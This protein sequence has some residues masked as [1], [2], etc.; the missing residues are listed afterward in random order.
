LAI[1]KHLVELMGGRIRLESVPGRGSKFHIDL[2][3]PKARAAQAA[4]F[5]IRALA[6]SRMLVVDDNH[7]NLEILQRQLEAWQVTVTCA[8]SGEQA[9]RVMADAAAA[10]TG[11]N[12]AILDMHMPQ[13]DG[14]QLARRIKVQ[15]ALAATRLI[16]L[17]ST[18]AAGSS[19]ERVQAGILRCVSKPIRKLE[20]LDVIR[21]VT[22]DS[23]VVP[24]PEPIADTAVPPMLKTGQRGTVLL[25]EDNPVNQQVAKAM[26][27]NRGLRVEIA[28]NGEE[29]LARVA[30]G[31]F[32]L[33]LMDCQMPV[34]D[35]FQA[36]AAI[37]QSQVGAPR[38]LPIVALTANAME[39][40]RE[41]C[42]AAGMDDYLPKPH[43]LAQLERVVAR[44]LSPAGP[45]APSADPTASGAG[46]GEA[47]DDTVLNMKLLEQFRGLDPSGGMGLVKQIVEV[48]LNTAE[49]TV[50]QIEQAVAAGDA[51]TLRRAAHTLK[52]SSVN[53]GAERLSGLFRQLETFGR[54]GRLEEAQ[55]LLAGMRHAYQ[56]STAELEK[57]LQAN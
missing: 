17:T 38:R 28:N 54:E 42:L 22:G 48:Y 52:S 10:G 25:V 56:R 36:T 39:G 15:P 16:M 19:E 8:D 46:R 55:S 50:C 23:V 12:L 29:A 31:N 5:D 3:L 34:M 21:S 51:E 37:R 33:V 43:T 14:L 4:P 32:D 41:R 2:T 1:C 30:A 27:E 20:L 11:F 45:D 57:L 6:G 35:G 53:V 13:M 47:D 44:W 7:T 9:L 40:D 26:L 24:A 18:H 49:D